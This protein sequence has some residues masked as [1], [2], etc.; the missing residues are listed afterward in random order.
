MK[1]LKLN[2]EDLAVSSFET[3]TSAELRGTIRAAEATDLCSV[4]CTDPFS[5]LYKAALTFSAL[6]NIN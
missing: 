6:C 3:H 4:S 5:T 1:K 2:L